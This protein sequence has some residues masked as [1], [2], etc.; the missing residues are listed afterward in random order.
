[1]NIND[2]VTNLIYDITNLMN[3]IH[4]EVIDDVRLSVDNVMFNVNGTDR[5]VN[6]IIDDLGA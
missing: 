2:H 1:M 5:I 6:I 4:N 3:Q